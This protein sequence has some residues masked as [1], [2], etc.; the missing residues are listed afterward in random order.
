MR[1][2]DILGAEHGIKTGFEDL[3]ELSA[4]GR[5]ADCSH[6]NEPGCAVRAAVENGE[7]SKDRYSSD[8]KLKRE[9]EFD[10]Y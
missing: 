6:E 7:L 10:N 8:I 4:N 5:Y 1:E 3:V 2:L 9:S